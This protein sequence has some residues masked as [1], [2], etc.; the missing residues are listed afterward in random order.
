[1]KTILV[2]VCLLQLALSERLLQ[3]D[4]TT[5]AEPETTAE[6]A[7]EPAAEPTTEPAADNTTGDENTSGSA[8]DDENMEKKAKD[9]AI[10]AGVNMAVNAIIGI[11]FAVLSP[12]TICVIIP[13]C[14]ICCC[15]RKQKKAKKAKA[16]KLAAEEAA[17][18]KI[19]EKEANMMN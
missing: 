12:I 17:K 13:I 10:S 15:V 19:V 3:T 8:A 4:P 1:M 7:A 9:M 6:P 5:T 11:V 16:L 2:L 14:C 18:P